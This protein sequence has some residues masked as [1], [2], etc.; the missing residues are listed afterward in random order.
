MFPHSWGLKRDLFKSAAVLSHD[1]R[2]EMPTMTGSL[3]PCFSKFESS[4][5]FN[6]ESHLFCRLIIL[7]FGRFLSPPKT[8]FLFLLWFKAPEPFKELTLRSKETVSTCIV[9]K[10]LIWILVCFNFNSMNL[11]EGVN[12]DFLLKHVRLKY[13]KTRGRLPR[14]NGAVSLPEECLA[15]TGF[16][17]PIV[18]LENHEIQN[19]KWTCLKRND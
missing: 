13:V 15:V 4:Y 17:R 19:T 14:N 11:K 10:G 7:Y 2:G 9:K 18:S 12:F 1:Q 8:L 5:K 6:S 3:S 16:A